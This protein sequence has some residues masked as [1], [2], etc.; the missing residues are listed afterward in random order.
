M[1]AHVVSA[2]MLVWQAA[3]AKDKLDALAKTA[4][5]DPADWGK[6]AAFIKDNADA[7]FYV[8]K[9]SSAKYFIFN[10]LPRIDSYATAIKSKDLSIMEIPAESFAS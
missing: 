4:G 5:A 3:I 9:I 8:G 10:V 6:W 2:Y 1:M 7:A